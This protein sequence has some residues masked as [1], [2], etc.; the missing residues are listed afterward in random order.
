MEQHRGPGIWKG[1][2]RFFFKNLTAIFCVVGAVAVTYTV[3]YTSCVRAAQQTMAIFNETGV[4][5]NKIAQ[6]ALLYQAGYVGGELDSQE[7]TDYALYGLV[8]GTGDKYGTYVNETDFARMMDDTQGQLVGIG[9]NVTYRADQNTIRVM[10]VM[11]GSS[12]Q[13]AGIQPNDYLVA[14]DG[15]QLSDIGYYAFVQAITGEEGTEVTVDVE[16][17]GEILSFTMQRT[18]IELQSVTVEEVAEGIPC[19]TITEFN[20]KTPE[21]FAAAM[22]QVNATANLR[23][24][25][26]DLR[27]N[28]GGNAEAVGAVLD[29]ILPECTVYRL[30]NKQGEETMRYDSDA[31]TVLPSGIPVVVLCNSNT[32]S[33]AE[34]FT[35]SLQ[36]L[37]LATVVGETT[38]GKGTGVQIIGLGDGSGLVMST[39]LYYTPADRNLEGVGVIPDVE[40]VMTDEEMAMYYDLTL[41]QDTQMQK[42]LGIIYTG[43]A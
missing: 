14:V 2:K 28:S 37:K 31:Q 32:A 6:V 13:A 4:D 18:R 42:A 8:Q 5:I 17:A 7:M 20:E 11:E 12:A 35:A 25:V 22:Q 40:V 43:G 33:A 21:Q 27:N 23:G 3:T 34:L 10:S 38:Y 30:V 19:V 1:L 15:Q 26:F 24:L 39:E 29:S 16:R 41:E 9:V 36:D